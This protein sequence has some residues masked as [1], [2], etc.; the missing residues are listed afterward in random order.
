MSFGVGDQVVCVHNYAKQ[1]DFFCPEKGQVYTIREFTSH[2]TEPGLRLVEIVNPP[3]FHINV[4]VDEPAF[5]RR[6][7][8]PVRK[9]SIEV[10]TRL[11]AP[12]PERETV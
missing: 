3:I 12:T 1:P 5:K 4:G 7:F 2:G 6:H 10:F 8:R 9:T 11:L